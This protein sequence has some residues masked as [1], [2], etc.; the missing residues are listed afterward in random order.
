MS[1]SKEDIH[2]F[3]LDLHQVV[4]QSQRPE[5]LPD[6]ARALAMALRAVGIPVD[7]LQ[8]PLSILFGLKHPVYAGIILTWTDGQGSN[9]WL[10]PRS[11]VDREDSLTTLRKSPFAAVVL[12]GAPSVRM[13]RGT[14]E[15]DEQPLLSRL[16]EAGFTDYL[17]TVTELPD[18]ARQVVSIAT[19]SPGGLGESV[20][21]TLDGLCPV[22][23]LA[24]FGIYQ[25]QTSFQIATTYLGQHTGR[26]VMEGQM[27]RG[28]SEAMRAAIA[29]MDIREFTRLSNELGVEGMVPL[30]NAS[31]EAIDE[32]VRPLRGEMLKFMGDAA[33]VVFP[34]TEDGDT[35][36]I[37]I[38]DAILTAID[39]VG[40]RTA[41]LGT[42]I[43]V[44]VGLHIGD[45]LYGN[46]GAKGRHD[47]TVMG[48]AVN[49]AS[50]LEGLT[51]Q[52]ST[53]LV[54]SEQIATAC[55][56]TCGSPEEAAARLDASVSRRG[57]VSVKGEPR[58]LSVWTIQRKRD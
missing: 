31:F 22:L 40:R 17:A 44:G 11:E 7:R 24:L 8:L 28:R 12:D 13:H 3:T 19:R 6:V 18:G 25:S 23:S 34:R 1:P 2:K 16:G 4:A 33:L 35:P 52:F 51:K 39:E 49:L 45:V 9:A 30:L 10:R 50:R 46:V 5:T 14:P 38:I 54:V 47:F 42:T 37:E 27:G 57:P 21:A 20:E 58:P 41:P 36:L 55:R 26:L 43:R 56:D 15:W 48:P 53:D 29:F 32:A